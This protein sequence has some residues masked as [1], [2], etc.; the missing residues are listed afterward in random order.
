MLAGVQ[1]DGIPAVSSFACTDETV[2]SCLPIGFPILG[3][4]FKYQLEVWLLT[5]T[6]PSLAD[7]VRVCAVLSQG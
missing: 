7:S 4:S 5:G 3:L 2:T 1:T 6:L